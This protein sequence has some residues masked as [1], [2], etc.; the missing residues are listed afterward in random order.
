[1]AAEMDQLKMFVGKWKCEGKAFA[2]P[3]TGPEHNFQATAEGKPDSGGHWQAFSYEEKKSKEHHALKV[4]GLWGWDAGNKRFVRAAVD[5]NGG[6]DT[7]TSPG[8]Q[9]DKILWTGELSGPMGRLP[10]HHTFTKKSDKEWSFALE[11]KAPDGKWA[12]LSEVACKK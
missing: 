5:D 6:W 7:A 12:P 11:V 9:A 8:V 2:N 4:H 1:V 10:F 3:M